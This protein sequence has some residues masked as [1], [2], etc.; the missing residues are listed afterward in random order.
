MRSK[1]FN[2]DMPKICGGPVHRL[3]GNRGRTP[4]VH[5][6]NHRTAWVIENPN[7]QRRRGGAREITVKI[8]IPRHTY[9]ARCTHK[10]RS[11]LA[12]NDKDK[13]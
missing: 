6:N 12:K 1:H 8:A 3:D 9:T 10:V 13:M 7:F 4:E 11:G 5:G 2:P